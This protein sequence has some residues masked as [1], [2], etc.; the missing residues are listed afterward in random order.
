MAFTLQIGDKAP[1]FK[2]PA[3]DGKTYR[4]ADF[5]DA[6]VLVIF[7]SCNHCPYV[8]GSDEVTRRTAEQ[9]I[10]QG[11]K[12]VAINSNSANTYPEDDFP[13]MVARMKEKKFPWLY[14]RDA[15][16]E[17]ALAYGALWTPHFYVFDRSRKLVYTGRGVDNPRDTSRMTV[18]DLE[19][20]LREHLA[21]KPVSKPTTNPVGCNI[22]WE[23]K[24]QHWMPPD[25]CDLV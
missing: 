6:K 4:L 14:L 18:N 20:A 7:F 5:N 17:V 12:F 8:T 3:T 2:L 15:S 19:N 16:Q 23:G 11:V 25:A 13:Q 24:D 10:P 22:K 21:G 1:D 9:F